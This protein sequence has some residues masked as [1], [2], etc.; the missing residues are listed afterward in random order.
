M[1]NI[2]KLDN[3]YSPEELI[4]A[5]E[6]FVEMYNH[7]R[8]HESLNNLT[9]ADVY[10]CRGEKILKERERIKRECFKERKR[11]YEKLKVKKKLNNLVIN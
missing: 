8:Y 7:E 6:I 5:L 2:I 11:N 4:R 1:K 9:P 10:Y 3:Y